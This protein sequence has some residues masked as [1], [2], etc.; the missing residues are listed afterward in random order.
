[1]KRTRLSLSLA[2]VLP[3]SLA[4]QQRIQVRQTTLRQTASA[5]GRRIGS[6]AFNDK[7]KIVNTVGGFYQIYSYRLNARG[8]VYKS[9][10]V[11]QNKFNSQ[12][13]MLRDS[14]SYSKDAVTAA[15]K[16]F[17]KSETDYRG[18]HRAAR[19]DLVRRI[20]VFHK[21]NNSEDWWERFRKE[22]ALGEFRVKENNK[23]YGR[24]V[25]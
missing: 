3:L 23:Y 9:A 7:V 19:H 12:Y 6:L 1:M 17:S 8:Y 10:V 13:V 14:G 18:R 4:A 25:R 22:G 15:T 16:G 5:F 11:N 21:F 24:G 2:L 20:M